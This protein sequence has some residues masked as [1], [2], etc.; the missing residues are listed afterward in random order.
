MV[1]KTR[2]NCNRS[3]CLESRKKSMFTLSETIPS[4]EFNK[5]LDHYQELVISAELSELTPATVKKTIS[6][7]RNA[8]CQFKYS[9][10]SLKVAADNYTREISS[11]SWLP[12]DNLLTLDEASQLARDQARIFKKQDFVI[13]ANL[14]KAIHRYL[15]FVNTSRWSALQLIADQHPRFQDALHGDILGH[16]HRMHGVEQEPG[17]TLLKKGWA[18]RYSF[19]QEAVPEMLSR[20]EDLNMYRPLNTADEKYWCLAGLSPLQVG[21]L[22]QESILSLLATQKQQENYSCL[23]AQE[24][25]IEYVKLR[26]GDVQNLI[27]LFYSYQIQMR[28]LRGDDMSELRGLCIHCLKPTKHPSLFRLSERIWSEDF[29]TAFVRL[30]GEQLDLTLP[31]EMLFFIVDTFCKESLRRRLRSQY[32]FQL[33]CRMQ[34]IAIATMKKPKSHFINFQGFD[35]PIEWMKSKDPEMTLAFSSIRDKWKASKQHKLHDPDNEDLLQDHYNEMSDEE[36]ALIKKDQDELE[37]D[38]AENNRWFGENSD[39]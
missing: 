39:E 28:I 14:T 36:L 27:S 19:R 20:F 26:N 22:Q 24:D 37:Q 31:K 34:R 25:V 12:V 9:E 5:C 17:K 32:K 16:H 11:I 21:K 1:S 8:Q 23:N 10:C 15:A 35:I 4:V 18:T 33:E 30:N 3:E 13:L 38:C 7:N 29:L 6:M 2:F